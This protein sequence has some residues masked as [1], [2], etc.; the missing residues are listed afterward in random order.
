MGDGAMMG[1]QDEPE[2]LFYKFSLERHVPEDHLLRQIDAVLDLSG[3]RRAL[4]PYYAAGGRP[5]VD[6]GLMIRMLLVGYAFALR[7]ERR[8]CDEVHLNLAYRWFCRLG[9]DGD[10]PDHPTSPRTDT[11]ASARAISCASC[12]RLFFAQDCGLNRAVTDNSDDCELSLVGSVL[13]PNLACLSG[14]RDA[15]LGARGIIGH[16]SD[17]QPSHGPAATSAKV[18]YASDENLER[19]QHLRRRIRARVLA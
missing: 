7:S 12:S 5:S 3:I 17:A 4:A 6:P 13:R 9:L 2:R 10:V 1:R 11:A 8:L 16:G 19:S 14:P 18:H 15:S